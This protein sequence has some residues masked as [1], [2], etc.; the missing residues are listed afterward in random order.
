MMYDESIDVPN[1]EEVRSPTPESL[2]SNTSRNGH[3]DPKM[4]EPMRQMTSR[5]SK[6]RP[7][8]GV[9]RGGT[10]QTH[11]SAELDSDLSDNSEDDDDDVQAALLE[12]SYNPRDYDHLNVSQDIREV[13]QYITCYTPQNMELDYKLRPFVPDFIPAVGDIDAFLKVARPDGQPDGLGLTVLDEP[14]VTQS[15]PAVLCLQLRV[16]TKQSSAKAMVVKKV[17]EAD[18]NQKAIDR[19]IHD[20]SELHKSKPAPTVQYSRPMPDIDSLMQEWP[21]QFEEKLNQLGLSTGE[22]DCDLPTLVDIIC[23]LFDIPRY[24]SRIE[25]LHVLFSLY[26]A[27]KNSQFQKPEDN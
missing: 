5:M 2:A 11:V 25:S 3:D 17:E 13:F 8:S 21:P 15:D 18:K 14:C 22:L 20:I 24:E 26:S 27:I 16:T 19:W 7:M 4:K 1:A 9:V 12:G 10:Q 23:A 6:A